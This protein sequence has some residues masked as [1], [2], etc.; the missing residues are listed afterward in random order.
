M[1]QPLRLAPSILS[2]DFMRPMALPVD[3]CAAAGGYRGAIETLRRAAS[4]A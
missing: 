4:N 1:T 2:V 3:A